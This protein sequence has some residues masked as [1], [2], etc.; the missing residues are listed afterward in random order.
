MVGKKSSPSQGTIKTKEPGTRRK[1]RSGMRDDDE[2][3]VP[4]IH[5]NFRESARMLLQNGPARG[6]RDCGSPRIGGVVFV[7]RNRNLAIVGTTVRES[8]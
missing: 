1:M 7:A 3:S 2:G 8:R 4:A 5:G 6:R